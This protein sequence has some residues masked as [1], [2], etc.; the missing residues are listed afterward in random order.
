MSDNGS[1]SFRMEKF[2]DTFASYALPCQTPC[3]QTAPV[4]LSAARQ[5]NFNLLTGM[6]NL[7]CHTTSIRL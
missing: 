5:Q 7:Y 2:N 1:T 6:F 3:C 4:L